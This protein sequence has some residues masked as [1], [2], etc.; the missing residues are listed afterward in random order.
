M[1]TNINITRKL[2]TLEKYFI[3]EIKTGNLMVIYYGKYKRRLNFR[4]KKKPKKSVI[5]F[6]K[7]IRI[8]EKQ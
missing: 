2:T 8:G 4:K 7:Y 3:E 1:K 5:S 6:R